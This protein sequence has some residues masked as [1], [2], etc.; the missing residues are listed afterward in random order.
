M[1]LFP[2]RLL[3]SEA[4]R[5]NIYL[6]H[7]D[8]DGFPPRLFLWFISNDRLQERTPRAQGI[9][10][11]SNMAAQH[12]V[13]TKPLCYGSLCW[14]EKDRWKFGVARS[15][16]YECVF[17]CL[18]VCVCVSNQPGCK[19]Q[20]N[21]VFLVVNW[22]DMSPWIFGYDYILI[23]L[24]CRHSLVLKCFLN[25]LFWTNQTLLHALYSH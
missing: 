16:A 11:L 25:V 22:Y 13:Y 24:E 17:V 6:F 12:S 4:P 9:N 8:W 18:C 23:W 10:T 21:S 19:C 7:A 14:D 15:Q 5:S 3:I 20:T 1:N 2:C